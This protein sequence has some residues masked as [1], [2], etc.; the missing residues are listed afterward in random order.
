VSPPPVTTS[1]FVTIIFDPDTEAALRSIQL[2]TRASVPSSSDLPNHR[3]HVTVAAYDASSIAAVKQSLEHACSAQLQF[4]IPIRSLG[5]FL[6]SGTVFG[7]PVPTP[8][9]LGLHTH[10][11]RSIPEP[12]RFAHHLG[13]GNWIPHAT[14]VSGLDEGELLNAL[15]VVCR[16]F[17][18]ISATAIGVG[19]LDL[20]SGTMV[21]GEFQDSFQIMFGPSA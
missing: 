2:K 1:L 20:T 5:V 19:I 15:H 8:T 21:D 6:E 10:I 9:L 12:Q 4:A 17:E 14:I 11:T 3:P 7:Q 13:V 18:P 16:A